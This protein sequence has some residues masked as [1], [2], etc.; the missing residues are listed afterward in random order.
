MKCNKCHSNVQKI[1]LDNRKKP[2][3][4]AYYCSNCGNFWVKLENDDDKDS[5]SREN[6]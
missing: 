6:S 2:S 4:Y 1:L 5:Q 3:M